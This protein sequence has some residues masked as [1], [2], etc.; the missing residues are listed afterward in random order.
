MGQLHV[1]QMNISLTGVQS[2]TQENRWAKT[3]HRLGVMPSAGS[4]GNGSDAYE[5]ET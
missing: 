3:Q 2:C 5:A 1:A 4:L